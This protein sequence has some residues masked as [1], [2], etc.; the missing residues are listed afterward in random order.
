ME[1]SKRYNPV[2]VKGNCALIARTPYFCH[3]NF[4]P[5]DPCCHDNTFLDK[6][7]YNSAPVKDNC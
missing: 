4:S 7:D 3:L 6:I 5:A 1:I 2:P